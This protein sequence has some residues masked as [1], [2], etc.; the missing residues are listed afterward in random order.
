LSADR[1]DLILNVARVGF[2]QRRAANKRYRTRVDAM[3][4]GQE[5][6]PNHPASAQRA[7]EAAPRRQPLAAVWALVVAIGGGFACGWLM[8]WH[9]ILGA[10]ALWPLGAAGGYVSRRLTVGPSRFAA[11]CLVAACAVALLVAQICWIHWNMELRDDRWDTAIAWI[12]KYYQRFGFNALIEAIC[13]AFGAFSAYSTAGRRYRLVR[14][15]I[16]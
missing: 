13:A 5:G 7:A 3:S 8:T 6:S 12:G 9:P 2:R 16:D 1:P 14:E 11:W 10:I 15:Y 4:S